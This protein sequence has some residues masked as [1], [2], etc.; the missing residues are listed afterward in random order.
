MK[1]HS[2]IMC[3]WRNACLKRYSLSVWCIGGIELNWSLK[4]SASSSCVVKLCNCMPQNAFVLT[5]SWSS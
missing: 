5:V 1:S 3:M 2:K 4:E